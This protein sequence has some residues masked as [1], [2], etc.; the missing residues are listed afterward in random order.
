MT[1]PATYPSLW[2]LLGCRLLAVKTMVEVLR[3][4]RTH[5][6]APLA[7]VASNVQHA[8]RALEG[9]EPISLAKQRLDDGV[10]HV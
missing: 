5:F 2:E 9:C 8:L 4:R 6:Q 10:L 1:I 7:R 3:R